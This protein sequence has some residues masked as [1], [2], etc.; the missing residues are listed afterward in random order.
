MVKGGKTKRSTGKSSKKQPK[1]WKS[2]HQHLF[3]KAAKDSRIGRDLPP[4]RDLSRYVKWPRYV[5]LQRQRAIIQKRLKVPPSVNQFSKTLDKNQA[6]NLFRLLSHYR[7][8]SKVEKKQRLVKAA[9]SEAKNQ[10]VKQGTKPKVIKFGLNHIT[11]LVETRKAKLVVIAHDVVPLELVLWL[12]ALCRKMNVPY[13]I[14]KGKARL[15][16][17]VYQKT[18]TAVALTEVKKEDSHKLSQLISNFNAQF[19]DDTAGRKTWG[20]GIMGIKA[21]HIER[22]K[23]AENDRELAKQN[24]LM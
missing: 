24:K 6:A 9:S 23:K 5:R 20:G 8:E 11:D 22:A 3:K 10:D 14:V 15:G 17:L 19:T 7:P 16:H 13:C 18:A 2:Q 12:P 4:K 21:Q 1:D